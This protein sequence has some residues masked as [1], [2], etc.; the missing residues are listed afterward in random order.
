M[1]VGVMERGTIYLLKVTGRN[2]SEVH[3]LVKEYIF[4][5]SYGNSG[6]R[7]AGEY[8]W[9]IERV[10][11]WI[12]QS[13]SSPSV[14]LAKWDSV[15][16]NISQ[17][18]LSKSWFF[19]SENNTNIKERKYNSEGIGYTVERHLSPELLE[20]LHGATNSGEITSQK[21][22]ES[23]MQRGWNEGKERVVIMV[24]FDIVGRLNWDVLADRW[25]ATST[26]IMQG[27]HDILSAGD[28]IVTLEM[29]A[30]IKGWDGISIERDKSTYTGGKERFTKSDRLWELIEEDSKWSKL[31]N[32][33]LRGFDW[34]S[35]YDRP[36]GRSFNPT[37]CLDEW[38]EAFLSAAALGGMYDKLESIV[39]RSVWINANSETKGYHG[40]DK[41]SIEYQRL[42]SRVNNLAWEV[43]VAR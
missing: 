43:N 32:A 40:E 28:L 15:A 20:E 8:D 17:G 33:A 7:K 37:S 5:D 22:L 9:E 26:W 35:S 41:S 38:N 36:Y 24:P 19:D 1:P 29:G 11:D 6:D 12:K 10:I 34:A 13:G 42:A 2:I 31:W 18:Y 25:S 23:T 39:E 4:R 16:F 27:S 21:I 3:S 14:Y 30:S